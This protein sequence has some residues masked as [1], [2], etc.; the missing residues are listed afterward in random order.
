MATIEQPAVQ[1]QTVSPGTPESTNAL[2]V[3]DTGLSTEKIDRFANKAYKDSLTNWSYHLK[4]EWKRQSDEAL[5]DFGNDPVQLTV[6]LEKIRSSLLP[7]EVPANIKRSFLDD[8]F[9]DSASMI[10]K[11]SNE[12]QAQQR[13]D[14]KKNA[15]EYA[16][17]L[18]DSIATDFSNV[19]ANNAAA[20][21]DKRP[22][23]VEIYN[24]D[25]EELARVADL[26]DDDDNN[27]FEPEAREEMERPVYALMSGLQEFL[28]PKSLEEIEQW[29]KD[30]FDNKDSFV[31]ETGV[32]NETYDGMKKIIEQA[33][34]AR[35]LDI[36]RDIN[37]KRI[38]N[39]LSFMDNPTIYAARLSRVPGAISVSA[40]TDSDL[41]LTKKLDEAAK[42]IYD[43]SDKVGDGKIDQ[44]TL[45]QI[46]RKV[47]SITVDDL[48]PSIVDNNILKAY[49]ADKA[50]KL[51][52]ADK[53][54]IDLFH[55]ALEKAMTDTTFKQSVAALANK[56]NFDTMLSNT[57]YSGRTRTGLG[58]LRS[59]REEDT[60]YVNKLG[61]EAYIAAMRLIVDEG[62]PE[63]A[64]SLY[65]A[66]I[67]KAY[68]YV[69]RDVID[70]NY[71]KQQLENMGYA[72]VELN[73]NMSKIVGRLPNGEYIIED[74]GEKINGRI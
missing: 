1:R 19:L 59:K 64:L 55:S 39:C 45:Q 62:K 50:L 23:D 41:D 72:M 43:L 18:K 20:P 22:V 4:N 44:A 38:A 68:D 7:D 65:D 34:N 12:Q 2:K 3:K 51:A 74:T 70:P 53:E 5:R 28:D 61:R 13:A 52:G 33:K 66:Y 16:D 37:R 35:K 27:Y 32:D 40:E 67:Q 21:E 17:G 36:Q 54:Q 56:P 25:R 10:Q 15:K 8:T 49:E 63:E 69:K 11:A 47:A 26:K 48:D 29:E 58:A 6:A 30:Y 42:D 46:I 31:A 60:E 57:P 9:Y 14:T 73:G 24:K 71:V